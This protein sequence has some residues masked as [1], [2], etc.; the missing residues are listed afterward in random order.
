MTENDLSVQL[1]HYKKLISISND[2]ASM[3]ELDVLLMRIVEAAVDL[4]ET[5]SAAILLYDERLNQL[6][7]Q[8]ATKP[9]EPKLRGLKVPVDNSL[10]GWIVTHREPVIIADVTKDDRYYPGISKSTGLITKS[11]IGVP[12]IAKEKVNGVL[13]AINKIE[14]EF[15]TQDQDALMSL[16]TQAALAIENTRL[17]Q[18]FDLIAEFV[19]EIR[20]PLSSLNTAT[21][22]L[23]HPEIDEHKRTRL[24]ETIQRETHRLADMSTNFLNIARLE[25]GRTQFNIESFEIADLLSECAQLVCQDIE[26]RGLEFITRY[27]EEIAEV[28]GDRDRLKQVIINL[29][30]N[31]IKYNRPGGCVILEAKANPEDIHIVVKDNGIG[32]PEKY[33]HKLFSKF[34]RVPGSEHFAQGT[35]LGLSIVNRII[36]GHGGYIDVESDVDEGTTFSVHLPR[37]THTYK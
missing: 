6:Y 33:M 34:F 23:T 1:S 14:G 11:L 10:A 24:A 12:L 25:S 36:K 22:L 7:F 2:L 29:L 18:Q 28:E 27:A 21:H 37:F 3:L 15:S 9:N 35:G 20:T 26:S 19:H 13:E 8:A 5:E 4:T 17:F 30:S 16:A 31:A 32:I